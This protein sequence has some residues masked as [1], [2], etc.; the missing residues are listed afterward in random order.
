M[1]HIYS[2][3]DRINQYI[4]IIKTTEQIYTEFIVIIELYYILSPLNIAVPVVNL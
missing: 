2:F 4:S 1:V 3:C